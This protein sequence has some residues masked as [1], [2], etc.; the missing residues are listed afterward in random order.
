MSAQPG[1][2][3]EILQKKIADLLNEFSE[4][5]ISGEQFNVLYERYMSQLSTLERAL[6]LNES[7]PVGAA[8][9]SRSTSYIKS[10]LMGKPQGISIYDRYTMQLIRTLGKFDVS[11]RLVDDLLSQLSA[12]EDA[13]PVVEKII[14]GQWLLLAAGQYTAIATQF[15]HE[16]SARQAAHMKRLHSD[17]E[18]ANRLFLHGREIDH[19]Q[20]AFPFLSFIMGDE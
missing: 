13:E 5:K 2:Y 15:D 10:S 6:L 16:P 12:A 11:E 8:Q 14:E 18:E 4:G 19:E 7:D 20:M 3:R 9:K 1:S 17:F